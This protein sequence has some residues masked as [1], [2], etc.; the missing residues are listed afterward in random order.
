[1]TS[2]VILAVT[3][4]IVLFISGC[5]QQPKK[6]ALQKINIAFQEFVGYGPF[7]LAQEKGFF[8]E[9]GIEL[10]F[11]NE[12]LDSAR[13]DAFKAGML[14]CEAG[15]I[16]LL[17]S[18]RAFD[19]PIVAVM[20]ID[21]SLG[22]DGIVANSNIKSLADLIGK[23]VAL[24]RDDVGET[25]ISCVFFEEGL[26]FEKLNIVSK[27]PDEV[28]QAFLSN[29]TDAVVTW[30]P[31]LTDALK[32]SGAHLLISSKDKP[33]IIIDTLNLREDLVKNNPGLVKGLMRGWFKAINYYKEQPIEAS[34]IIAKH[35]DMTPEQY[36]KS[37]L[38][39]KWDDYAKQNTPEEC[40]RLIETFNV[41]SNIKYLNARI[42]NKPD[43]KSAI[44]NTLLKGLYENSR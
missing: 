11:I 1:M 21:E 24:A 31:Y 41:I 28:A 9:E 32:K 15:T 13:K 12:Q 26:P 19:T 38:V 29:E 2:K 33:G 25:F 5:S 6:P 8:E 27:K 34:N 39:L 22:V 23:K 40:L 20:E 35:Y 44:N 37:V 30:E 16:D 4:P 14:D 42:P 10:N 36:R 7:Y 43:A 18:K 3:L 17:V